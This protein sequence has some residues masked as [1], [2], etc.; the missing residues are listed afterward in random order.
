L[1]YEDHGP[2][3][4][5][6]CFYLTIDRFFLIKILLCNKSYYTFELGHSDIKEKEKSI[7]P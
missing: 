5:N 3:Y 2:F 7:L 4:I 6:D 1:F